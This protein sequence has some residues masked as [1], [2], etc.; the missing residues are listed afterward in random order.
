MIGIFDSGVGG[1]SSLK[2]LLEICPEYDYI[3]FADS[4]RAPYGGKSPELIYKYTKESVEALFEKG[5]KIVIL[6]CNTASI[7]ALRRLQSEYGETKKV[8][9][10]VIP[11]AEQALSSSRYGV[12]GVT[13]TKTTISLHAFQQELERFAPEFYTPKEKKSRKTIQV[14]EQAC[15]LLVPL[16]E[17]DW[18]K[19]PE[20]KMIL[21]KYL[22]PLKS[23][24]V[25][26]LILGCTH[27]PLI[28]KQFQKIMG[29][30]CT[31]IDSGEAQAHALKKYFLNHPEIEQQLSKEKKRIFLTT[32]NPEHFN[33]KAKKFLGIT[34]KA[35]QYSLS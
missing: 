33:K 8:L 27:Y 7:I 22:L 28:K 5:A 12:I 35:E 34:I 30:N 19:K 26:T 17:E 21:K 11:T 31:I 20:T 10:V 4:L 9:G 24:H 32:D 14:F 16:I 23:C 18:E 2:K 6:A 15:P 1:L 29:K 3:Y 13:G 25:D